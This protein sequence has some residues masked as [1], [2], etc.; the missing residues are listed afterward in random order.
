MS[1]FER[2]KS[3]L[4][5]VT[6]ISAAPSDLQH[7]L[8]WVKGRSSEL[9]FRSLDRY[10]NH[11]EAHPDDVAWRSIL[12]RVAVKESTLFRSPQQFHCL[13]TS[14]LP[15]ILAGGDGRLRI[16]SAGCARGEEPATLALTLTE[17]LKGRSVEWSILAT[18]VDQAALDQA[19]LGRFPDRAIQ[20]VPG[21]LLER[22]FHSTAGGFQLSQEIQARIQYR[23]V[24]LVRVPIDEVEGTFD[25]IFLRNV[26]I[27]FK[28]DVQRRIIR[29]MERALKPTGFLFVGVT[30]TLRQVTR[31]LVPEDR[32]G[33]FVYRPANQTAAETDQRRPQTGEAD[34]AEGSKPPGARPS[35]NP[36]AGRRSAEDW[37]IQGA[38]AEQA[39]DAR[40]ALRCYRAALYL[41]SDLYQV[42][43]RLGCCLWEVG[44]ESRAK[45]EF[46]A[47]LAL[48]AEGKGDEIT[49]PGWSHGKT[50]TD[51]A[52]DARRRLTP[53]VGSGDRSRV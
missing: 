5:R 18:D 2:L 40:T 32:A 49:V 44:W 10:F 13:T 7:L 34:S 48:L 6:G 28:P 45:M 19:R 43:Y 35:G 53:G 39:G 38:R 31:T 27:Y 11:L 50:R 20:R 52:S 12:D 21:N 9:G 30:E 29:S 17:A 23:C 14:V 25:L 26:L 42:R 36:A 16:W 22:Y 24:N 47:V 8:G 46:R 3:L 41:R 4:E 1:E 37:A 15:E 51:I 33:V